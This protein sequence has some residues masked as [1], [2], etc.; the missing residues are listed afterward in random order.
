MKG[1]DGE[2]RA[3]VGFLTHFIVCCG[4]G[5]IVDD[6]HCKQI[7][8]DERQKEPSTRTLYWVK[9]SAQTTLAVIPFMTSRY[10][11]NSNALIEKFRVRIR[12][13][14]GV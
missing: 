11:L 1:I 10:G 3:I 13:V 14:A 8:G 6:I 7:V 2:N 12:E 5:G 4:G 9:V